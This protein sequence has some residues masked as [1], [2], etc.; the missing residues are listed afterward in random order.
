M[1]RKV[2]LLTAAEID[3]AISD[4]ARHS[5]RN[6]A[7]PSEKPDVT[8]QIYLWAV[9]RMMNYLASWREHRSEDSAGQAEL[10]EWLRDEPRRVTQV[11]RKALQRLA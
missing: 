8:A 5:K 7:F 9:D 6:K 3:K 2:R 11:I 10:E 4:I 1:T